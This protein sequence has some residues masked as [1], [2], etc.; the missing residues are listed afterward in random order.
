MERQIRAFIND[1]IP[2]PPPEPVYPITAIPEGLG[3]PITP[4][5]LAARC[6]ELL[7]MGPDHCP[8]HILRDDQ[9]QGRESRIP[10]M[11]VMHRWKI[12]M[13]IELWSAAGSCRTW[14]AAFLAD[15]TFLDDDR[16]AI[17][18]T[19]QPQGKGLRTLWQ[20]WFPPD[21]P[22]SR[23]E[24]FPYRRPPGYSKGI[25]GD[26]FIAARNDDDRPRGR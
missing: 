21:A 25:S 15:W 10:A 20:R 11:A 22:P 2:A 13:P 1:H 24:D 18:K 17:L 9:G 23:P 8:F 16:A 26:Q 19:H 5:S 12:G 6:E 4:A 7:D 3:D 14:Q